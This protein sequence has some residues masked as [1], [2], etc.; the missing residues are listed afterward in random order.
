MKFDSLFLRRDGGSFRRNRE[1]PR[2]PGATMRSAPL[3]L[4]DPDDAAA[5]ISTPFNSS[6]RGSR[7]DPRR[8]SPRQLADWAHEMYLCRELSWNEYCLAGFPAEL[9]PHYNRTVGALTGNLAQ[10]DAPRNMIR[11]WE[12][13]LAFA[14]RYNDPNEPEVLRVEK[15]L[16]LLK[17]NVPARSV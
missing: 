9:H 3:A 7:V 1:E 12:E 8:M 4:P 17:Q 13:R 14:L 6:M 2:F 15:L 10:P 16:M 5:P 11:V